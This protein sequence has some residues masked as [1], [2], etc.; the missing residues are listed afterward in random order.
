MKRM[1]SRRGF[2]AL[3]G[4]LTAAALVEPT[5]FTAPRGGWF[6]DPIRLYKGDVFTIAGV[7]SVN[8][9]TYEPTP[10][11]QQFVAPR[12]Y[13]K[14]DKYFELRFPVH[15][16]VQVVPTDIIKPIYMGDR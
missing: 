16:D 9:R 6:H 12:D 8:P 14:S 10:H 2:L 13:R 15:P 7:Y 11:L 4:M 3:A 1:F 5:V